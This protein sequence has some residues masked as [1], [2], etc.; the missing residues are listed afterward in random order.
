MEKPLVSVIIPVYNAEKYICEALD[1]VVSQTYPLDKIEIVCVDDGSTD[2]SNRVIKGWIKED[3]CAIKLVAKENG[4]SASARNYGI[5][6]CGGEIIQLLDADDRLLP[7]KIEKSVEKLMEDDSVGL[8]YSYY[9][10]FDEGGNRTFVDRKPFSI[11]GQIDECIVTTACAFKKVYFNAVG[12]YDERFQLIEDYFLYTELSMVCKFVCLEEALFEYRQE[13]QNKTATDTTKTFGWYKE[14]AWAKRSLAKKLGD[15]NPVKISVC[16]AGGIGDL[17]ALSPT[18]KMFKT[19][20]PDSEIVH[21][22]YSKPFSDILEFN[23]YIDKIHAGGNLIDMIE[24]SK[25]KYPQHRQIMLDYFYKYGWD[26]WK[27]PLHLM[28]FFCQDVVGMHFPLHE[29]KPEFYYNPDGSDFERPDKLIKDIGE[30]IVIEGQTRSNKEGKEWKHFD[31]VYKYLEDKGVTAISTASSDVPEVLGY[32]NII[33]VRNFTIRETARLIEMSKWV[34]TCQSGLS[35][36]SDAFN[37]GGVMINAGAPA[38]YCGR[39][40]KWVVTVDQ[41]EVFSPDSIKVEDVLNAIESFC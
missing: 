29:Y 23:P 17:V 33:N 10:Q 14:H 30:Y 39:T 1:S 2:N 11:V 25:V 4:G 35:W 38:S 20:F 26:F 22:S 34:L 8:V 41:K 6:K 5:A 27:T 9:I 7:E 15:H 36:I 40:S 19:M 12:G 21:W 24:M 28:Q 13:G 3:K 18:Y 37:K 31:E 32:K 16:L